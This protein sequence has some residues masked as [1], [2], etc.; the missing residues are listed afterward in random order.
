MASDE[1]ISRYQARIDHIDDKWILKDGNGE[2]T[3]PN[4]EN[5]VRDDMIEESVSAQKLLVDQMPFDCIYSRQV[6]EQGNPIETND[7]NV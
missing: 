6:D 1:S 5:E 2:Q 3:N 4:F 7:S